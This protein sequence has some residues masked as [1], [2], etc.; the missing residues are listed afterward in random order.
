[1]QPRALSGTGKVKRMTNQDWEDGFRPNRGHEWI[2]N[3]LAP[4]AGPEWMTGIAAASTRPTVAPDAHA[5]AAATVRRA[6]R[7]VEAAGRH[8]PRRDCAA[9]IAQTV[10]ARSHRRRGRPTRAALGIAQGAVSKKPK[11]KAGPHQV[12]DLT[13]ESTRQERLHPRAAHADP[14]PAAERLAEE[15][16]A[17]PPAGTH[18]TARHPL[19]QTKQ[20]T[21]GNRAK[22]TK[23]TEAPAERKRTAGRARAASLHAQ[24]ISSVPNRRARRP[25]ASAAPLRKTRPNPNGATWTTHRRPHST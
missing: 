8:A 9:A 18:D 21:R 11:A 15:R 3:V 6:I 19:P 23:R 22:P 4:I 17:T 1:M 10:A 16:S 14:P 20:D 12:I 2:A 5:V 25:S 24:P 13:G 7:E